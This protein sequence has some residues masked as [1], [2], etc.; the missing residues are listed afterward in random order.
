MRKV[1]ATVSRK[2]RKTSPR[3]HPAAAKAKAKAAGPKRKKTAAKKTPTKKAPVKK[4]AKAA[5]RPDV[6]RL[7]APARHRKPGH[8]PV[9]PAHMDPRRIETLLAIMAALRA[10][11]TGCPWDLEQTFAT[12]APYTIE[13]AYEV[14]DAIAKGDRKA[15]CEELGD[16]LLQPVYHAQMAAE[17]GSFSFA[18]VVEAVCRKMI[19]RHPHV[20]GD[21]RARGAKLAKT[22][23][24]DAKAKEKDGGRGVL[25][26]VALALPALTR[27]VKL[28]D[29]AAK[30]G[31]DLPSVT[32]VHDKVAEEIAEFHEAE[33]KDKAAEFGDILFALSNVARHMG[34]DP[35]E[36][37]RLSNEKFV[38][39]FAYIEAELAK[40][41]KRPEDSDLDEMDGLW[42]EAKAKGL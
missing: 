34:I 5:H 2:V 14:A 29:K 19:R 12:I 20:F 33:H 1:A 39:R 40:R 15:L 4:T 41:G 25:A 7:H 22:F 27:A 10:P 9:N 6:S 26:D 3:T 32:Y 17:E 30:V 16:L 42:N 31:F 11:G 37:V 36:A 23:W 24:E 8:G 28:Q 38:R 35:E 13:E 21:D 18:D